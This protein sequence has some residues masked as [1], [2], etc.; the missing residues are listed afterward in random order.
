MSFLFFFSGISESCYA[1]IS[2]NE[3]ALRFTN[4][5]IKKIK[6]KFVKQI[7]TNW[8]MRFAVF[9]LSP[10]SGIADVFFFQISANLAV[11]S[12]LLFH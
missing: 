10:I 1:A 2:K 4:T 7:T 9:R 5:L 3:N 11:L 8:L 12:P 6:M